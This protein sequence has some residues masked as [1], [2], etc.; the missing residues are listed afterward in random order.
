MKGL[1]I[2]LLV[3]NVLYIG[4]RVNQQLYGPAVLS[5][6]EAVTAPLPADVPSLTLLSELADS[7]PE[8]GAETGG[9]SVTGDIAP[10]PGATDRPL[11][12]SPAAP[13]PEI[14]AGPAVES[15]AATPA[16]DARA[17]GPPPEAAAK[18]KPEQTP[19]A[20]EPAAVQAAATGSGP[21]QTA[22]VQ[23][24]CAT[25]GPYRSREDMR[26][27][28]KDLTPLVHHAASRTEASGAARLYTVFLEPAESEAEAE[29]RIGELKSKGITD[30]FLI[31]RGEMRNAI[32]VG[33]FRSQD[34]VAKRLAELERT[35]YKTVVVPKSGGREQYWI[36]VAYDAGPESLSS[37]KARAGGVKVIESKCP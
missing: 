26:A 21:G 28:I 34:S 14:P 5:R 27:A 31:R 8:R 29:V 4:W 36:D 22:P 17:A 3:V 18:A 6:D 2:L 33:T 19:A 13:E 1:C 7:P 24:A 20:P 12:A 30:Y 25:I 11:A 15:D 37:L 32:Q 10:E 23:L 16:T 9:A 35:G